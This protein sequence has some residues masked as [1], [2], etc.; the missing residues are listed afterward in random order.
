[1]LFRNFR[2]PVGDKPSLVRYIN[3]TTTPHNVPI[4][5]APLNKGP[6]NVQKVMSST[7]DCTHPGTS[8]GVNAAA[9]QDTLSFV[10]LHGSPALH[11][12]THIAQLL[13]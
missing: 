4:L 7:G 3:P 9:L 2:E 12:K 11:H 13:I 6:P 10:T 1:M 8:P 5:T